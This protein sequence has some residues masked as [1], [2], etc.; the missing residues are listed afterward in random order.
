MKYNSYR[1]I[2]P[3]RPQNSVPSTDLNYYDNGSFIA[4]P[5]LNGS[6]CVI[7]T[8]GVKVFKMNRHNDRLTR[9]EINDEEILALYQGTCLIGI[10]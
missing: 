2:Y 1:Y 7:F 8:D 10:F 3:P 6:N 9:F 5:K 4:Q